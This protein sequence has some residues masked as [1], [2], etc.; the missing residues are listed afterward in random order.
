MKPT[1]WNAFDLLS[2][3]TVERTDG[4]IATVLAVAERNA[5]NEVVTASVLVLLNS[6]SPGVTP[7]P[8]RSRVE[9]EVWR[10]SYG[11][12]VVVFAANIDLSAERMGEAAWDYRAG[13]VFT[14]AAHVGRRY[15]E[16]DA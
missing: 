2:G 10:L 4:A 15:V 11:E 6:G 12:D 9:V 7:A 1:V 8:G 16:V 14:A 13:Q 3:L 5:E